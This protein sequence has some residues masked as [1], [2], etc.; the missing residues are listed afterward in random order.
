M[1]RLGK[2]FP[3]PALQAEKCTLQGNVEGILHVKLPSCTTTSMFLLLI[4]LIYF[5]VVSKSIQWLNVCSGC[6]VLYGLTMSICLCPSNP[7]M[8]FEHNSVRR[9]LS[10]EQFVN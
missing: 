8:Y 1:A 7:F 9:G 5:F 3:L 2:N 10:C 4:L 6:K